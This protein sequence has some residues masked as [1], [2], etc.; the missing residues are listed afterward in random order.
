MA[1]LEAMQ[2]YRAAGLCP[3]PVSGK[4][5]A[6]SSWTAFQERMPTDEEM[7]SWGSIGA[8][9][10]GIVTGKVSG[11]LV[12][13]DLDCKNDPTGT[14]VKE[15]FALAKEM[16]GAG[17]IDACVAQK[18]P[19]GG[20]H[21]VF[22]CPE[23]HDG[24]QVFAKSDETKKAVIETRG[25]GGQFV[26]FPSPGYQAVKAPLEQ[27]KTLSLSD[28]ELL[29]SAARAIDR[30]P[31][32][33]HT[34]AKPPTSLRTTGEV[35]PLDD[36][37]ARTS[38]EDMQAEIEAVGFALIR[39]RGEN[40]HYRRPG[41]AGRDTSATLHVGLKRF[42]VFTTS[43]ELQ[44]GHA[45][46][47]AALMC[48]LH[49]NGDWAATAGALRR[50]GY[51]SP[52][53]PQPKAAQAPAPSAEA[54]PGAPFQA[55]EEKPVGESGVIILSPGTIREKITALYDRPFDPGAST[56]WAEVD[57]HLRIR[58]RRV[59][60]VTG[61]PGSGK[62]SI[63]NHLFMNLAFKTGWRIAVFSPESESPEDL[64]ANLC[65]IR[66]GKPFFGPAGVRMTQAEAGR[67]AADIAG[68][69]FFLDQELSGATFPELLSAA[70]TLK[71]DALLLDPWNRITHVRPEGMTETEYIGVCLAKAAAFSKT[72]DLSLWIVAHPQKIRRDKEGKLQRPGLY[73]ISGSAN[74]A[75]MA[76]NAIMIW[77]DYEKGRT[78]IE[79]IKVRGKR[80]GEPGTVCLK[81]EKAT[82]RF[83]PWTQADDFTVNVP[84]LKPSLSHPAAFRG[85]AA[86]MP[87][88]DQD[89]AEPLPF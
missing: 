8:D 76:D 12:C 65:E 53:N 71:P 54:G 58:K 30:A 82:G 24:N 28:A 46:S 5:P 19:S 60:L 69:F 80:D 39:Q 79:V 55:R 22:R 57:K 43:T 64:V 83:R 16:G 73:D 40:L 86:S 20:Y 74:W 25:Q 70:A 33:G 29:F 34:E 51:G 2:R 7:A 56:G 21:L 14:M 63:L 81:F 10:V 47:P 67:A 27:V 3:I 77:R 45:Y 49:H 66:V 13:L 9:G 84:P 17:A 89:D 42:Y 23:I 6:L 38:V 26:A 41:K 15:F 11:G 85:A 59:T 4:R 36:Y 62:S 87:Q 72:Y 1:I 32:T 78:E 52:R 35:T 31:L 44:A 68:R 50:A 18:T 61:I 37:N 48:H 88:G 75:N